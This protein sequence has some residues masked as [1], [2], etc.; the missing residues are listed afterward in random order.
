MTI[1]TKK[2]ASRYGLIVILLL[3]LFI[4]AIFFYTRNNRIHLLS[5]NVNQLN[6]IESDYSQLDTC[7]LLLYRAD[8]NCRLF[9]ATGNSAYM[10]LFSSEIGRVSKILDTLQFRESTTTYSKNVKG[11]VSQKKAKMQVYAAKQTM[12]AK[13][14][15]FFILLKEK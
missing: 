4:S 9:E 12:A 15:S 10:K 14:A 1:N 13:T 8:N 3:A 6:S 2:S 7:V 11:L 5:E